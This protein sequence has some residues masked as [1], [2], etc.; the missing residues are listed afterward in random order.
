[1]PK[2]LRI[3]AVCLV[4]ALGLA[5]LALAGGGAAPAPK[6]VLRH[7]AHAPRDGVSSDLA[8][9]HNLAFAGAYDGFRIFDL[10]RP[11]AP[12]LVA[13]V[14][15]RGAQ[16][17]VSVAQAGERLLLFTSVDRA[18]TS[19]DCSSADTPPVQVDGTTY[20]TPG[21]EGIR[22]FD[23]TDPIAPRQIAAVATACG[24]HTHTVVPDERGHRLLLYVSSFPLGAGETP[25]GFPRFEGPRCETPHAKIPIVEV[26]L[27]QPERARVLKEQPLDPRT[28]P[29]GHGAGRPVIGCH[30]IQVYLSARRKLAAAACM[31]E[32]QLWDIS[33]PASPRTVGRI[34][35]IQN[36]AL[37]FWHSAAFTWDGRLV[38]FGDELLGEG[39][40]GRSER[41]GNI[42]IYRAVSPGAATRLLGRY[43]VPRTQRAYC[44]VHLFNVVPTGT[45]RYLAVASAY[46][47]GTS[48]FE[49]TKPSAP[50]ELAFFDPV[51]PAANT[52]SAYWYNGLVVSNDINRGVD[53]FRLTDRRGRAFGT[54][55]FAMLNPQTQQV[56]P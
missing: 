7:V 45:R 5:S 4:G 36:P 54:R 53:V 49:F 16:G 37:D 3:V 34:T 15:C 11:S 38:L 25:P 52:W 17:D 13:D 10:A 46:S 32:G 44:S 22:V 30:D 43:A 41:R 20:A 21:F 55:R 40:C 35:R 12:R 24:S 19:A 33:D 6:P 56:S 31:S 8:F 27:D 50:R 28:H 26:P 2:Q 23:V 48:V 39:G 1:M 18:Q 29:H 47:G 42:W 51:S 9:W 14:R